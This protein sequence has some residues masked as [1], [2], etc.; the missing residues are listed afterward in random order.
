MSTTPSRE[1]GDFAED[2]SALRSVRVEP[3][4]RSDAGPPSSTPGPHRLLSQATPTGLFYLSSFPRSDVG[5]T[6]H[7]RLSA[8]EESSGAVEAAAPPP[9][10]P[11]GSPAPPSAAPSPLPLPGAPRPQL[12]QRDLDALAP[13]PPLPLA[14]S[15]AGPSSSPAPADAPGVPVRSFSSA[16]SRP[17]SPGHAVA[18]SMQSSTNG[19]PI[20][21]ICLEPLTPE[22]FA[23][24]RAIRLQCGCRGDLP[25][26]HKK[27]AEEWVRVKGDNVCELCRQPIANM[28]AP[29]R[30]RRARGDDFGECWEAGVVQAAA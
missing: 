7:H 9:T 8:S 16:S 21:L 11:R 28:P 3:S 12:L 1:R 30:R 27:C 20:C 25:C 23:S 13:A 2:P 14:E 26:R 22:D 17:P 6:G 4:S 19:L 18:A 15:P 10:P 5:L 24:R 29:R